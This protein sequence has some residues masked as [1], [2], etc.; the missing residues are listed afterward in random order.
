MTLSAHSLT[1]SSPIYIYLFVVGDDLSNRHVDKN[2][3]RY[4]DVLREAVAIKSVS[5]WPETRKDIQVMMNWTK[6]KLEGLG[7]TCE[8]RD[9]GTQ[10]LPDGR[11]IPLPNVL[12]GSLGNVS[13]GQSLW[14]GI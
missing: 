14:G 6:A 11:V 8:L 9:V 5:A 4:I 2:K 1:L 3:T 7:A 13:A 12:F 10:T